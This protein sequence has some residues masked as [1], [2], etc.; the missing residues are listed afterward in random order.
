MAALTDK[1]SKYDRRYLNAVD[2]AASVFA[3]KGYHGAGTIDIANRLDIKQGSLYYYFRS[4]EAALEA[5]C[6]EGIRHQVEHLESVINADLSFPDVVREIVQYTL[7]SLKE[8]ADYMIVFDNDR[9]SIPLERRGKIREQSH[10]YH[11]LLEN[12]FEQARQ[13]G[14]MKPDLDVY[15]SV[16]AFTGLL[17]SVSSWYHTQQEIDLDRVVQ[18]YSELFLTGS[19]A[20]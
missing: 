2:A 13:K 7:M 5:V 8:R 12:I 10:I 3:D 20:G 14:E 17:S 4:K 15:I 1:K 16:R 11:K 18:Q 9:Q 19:L 6:L